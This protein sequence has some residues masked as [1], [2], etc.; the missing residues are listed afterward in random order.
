MCP[1]PAGPADENLRPQTFRCSEAS[2][3]VY[4]STRAQSVSEASEAGVGVRPRGQRSEA[5]GLTPYC[6]TLWPDGESAMHGESPGAK[7]SLVNRMFFFFAAEC[8]VCSRAGCSSRP[9]LWTVSVTLSTPLDLVHVR[10]A[11]PCVAL[12]A[13]APLGGRF[14]A[15]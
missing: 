6:G 15:R 10:R 13:G 8:A 7:Y 14:C 1:Y 12:R 3:N 4:L 5:S 11:C 2:E 9:E